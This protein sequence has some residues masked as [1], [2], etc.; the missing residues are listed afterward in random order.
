RRV[1]PENFETDVNRLWGVHYLPSR[2]IDFGY[3]AINVAGL[4]T[5][6]DVTQIPIQRALTT[7]QLSNGFSIVRGAQTMNVGG[8]VRN[9][10]QNGILDQ[11]VRGSM[12][13]SGALSGS[14]L[15]DLLLGFPSFGL[16]SQAD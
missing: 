8:E 13:F 7:Y 10:R 11:L 16:Q 1:L 6:G 5:V 9:T 14:G 2:P 12:S 3:P 15:S 4:S